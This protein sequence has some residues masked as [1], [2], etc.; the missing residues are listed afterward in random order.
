MTG[1][2]NFKVMLPS[3]SKRLE[4]WIKRVLIHIE[5]EF[6]TYTI[7]QDANRP[8]NLRKP[9][10]LRS[11]KCTWKTLRFW[12][13]TLSIFTSGRDWR[14]GGGRHS[15]LPIFCINH[16]QLGPDNL[17]SFLVV[18]DANKVHCSVFGNFLCHLRMRTTTR[19]I[20]KLDWG[21]IDSV[22]LLISFNDNS[23]L[24]SPWLNYRDT[25]IVATIPLS[26]RSRNFF[27]NIYWGWD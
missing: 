19:N 27:F 15:H 9:N 23:S 21:Q 10:V 7:S 24:I 1:E 2:E 6:V 5:Q 20:M 11:H 12:L 14:G 13:K 18:Y 4:A 3:H 26:R 25:T 22:L 17:L 16:M 8:S